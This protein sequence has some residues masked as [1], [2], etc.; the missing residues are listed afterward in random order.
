MTVIAYPLGHPRA[1][2]SRGGDCRARDL[3][4][5]RNV[6]GPHRFAVST[7]CQISNGMLRLTVGAAG[8]A[9]SLTVECWRPALP[10]GD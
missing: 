4:Q 3:D 6:H 10:I 8:A 9:P 2:A 7:H 1:A 5:A